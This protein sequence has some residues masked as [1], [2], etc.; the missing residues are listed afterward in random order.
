MGVFRFLITSVTVTL[1][2]GNP[3]AGV[4]TALIQEGASNALEN[5]GHP[6]GA[7]GLRLGLG[8]IDDV[9]TSSLIDD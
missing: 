5:D 7:A 1:A 3:I 9:A 2:T 6:E 4:G 8:S